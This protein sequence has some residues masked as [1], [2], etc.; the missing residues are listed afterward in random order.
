MKY[1]IKLIKDLYSIRKSWFNVCQDLENHGIIHDCLWAKFGNEERYHWI[2]KTNIIEQMAKSANAGN[3]T[4]NLDV[5]VEQTLKDYASIEEINKQILE[6]RIKF[7]T[8]HG[9]EF[10]ASLKEAIEDG[11]IHNGNLYD[12]YGRIV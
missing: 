8:E 7:I 6:D 12:S 10:R 3:D 5:L 9:D 4:L 1:A 2:T 11:H